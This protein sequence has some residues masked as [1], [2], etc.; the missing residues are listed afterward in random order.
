MFLIGQK[1]KKK[2]K[3][4]N[5]WDL[6]NRSYGLFT[7]KGETFVSYGICCRVKERQQWLY[8]VNFIENFDL[9]ELNSPNNNSLF[10]MIEFFII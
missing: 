2:K 4:N 8:V 1:K 9:S 6:K 10:F 5:K 3:K 7:K